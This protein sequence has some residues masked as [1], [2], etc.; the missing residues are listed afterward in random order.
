[1]LSIV[2]LGNGLD[3]L[4]LGLKSLEIGLG[5]EVIVPAHTFIASWIAIHRT[6]AKIVPVDV[7]NTSFNI[8]VDLI[9]K[10]LT[11]RLKLLCLFICTDSLV[12]WKV[13]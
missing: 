3:A 5:D 6:G 2:L 9:L 8:D 13:Y 11:K 4:F 1:M 10:K 7:D 12:T